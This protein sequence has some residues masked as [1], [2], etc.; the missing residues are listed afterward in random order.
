M[1]TPSDVGDAEAGRA[2][3]CGGGLARC[4]VIFSPTKSSPPLNST[5]RMAPV[6]IR[7][8]GE[9]RR[10]LFGG[11]VTLNRLPLQQKI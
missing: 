2:V 11:A 8:D 7:K 10:D 9:T 4:C 5:T 3:V 1:A 6:T